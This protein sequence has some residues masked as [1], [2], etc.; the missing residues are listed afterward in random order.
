MAKAPSLIRRAMLTNPATFALASRVRAARQAFVA[1]PLWLLI[2]WAALPL[3]RLP[4][5][6]LS[7]TTTL[8]LPTQ[9]PGLRAQVAPRAPD[10]QTRRSTMPSA[11]KA[12]QARPA[13]LVVRLLATLHLAPSLVKLALRLHRLALVLLARPR[14]PRLG[15]VLLPPWPHPAAGVVEMEFGGSLLAWELKPAFGVKNSY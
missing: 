5:R 15:N 10:Q 4:L 12:V 8:P 2:P 9:A 6:A 7:A 13:P 3:E 14:H 1:R 11:L